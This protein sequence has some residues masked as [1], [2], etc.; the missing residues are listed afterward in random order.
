MLVLYNENKLYMAGAKKNGVMSYMNSNSTTKIKKTFWQRMSDSNDRKRILKLI[1]RW[2]KILGFLFIIISMIWGCVQ[3][4]QDPYLIQE[5]TDMTGRRVYMAGVS[6]EIITSSLGEKPSQN[7]AVIVSGLNGQ[8]YAYNVISSWGEAFSKTGSPFYGFFV[9]PTAL[10]LNALIKG[11][12]GTLNPELGDNSYG[13]AVI[14]AIL[15]TVI[16]IKSISLAFTWK[17]Q[18]NQHKQQAFQLKQADIQAK[19][20]GDKSPQAR[21]KM[22][23]EM[24]ALQKREGF[25]PFSS[26]AGAFASMPFLFAIYAIVRSTKSL[27][28]ANVGLIALIEKPWSQL[29]N[30]DVIYLTLLAVYLPLQIVSMLLPLV[31]QSIKQKSITLTEAQR[32]SRK[33]QY[34]M[35]GVFAFVFI[36]VVASVASGVAIYWIFSSTYQII[37]TLAFFF[38]N[39][40]KANRSVQE[41]KRRKRQEEKRLAK[42]NK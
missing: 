38:W 34:I 20:K 8:Q 15:F 32:S 1:W 7:W 14:F 10:L 24:S 22:S 37:Q 6:F 42:L 40:H 41:V 16:I 33:K 27:K 18:V 5:V 2:I 21:Q 28:I 13:I 12:S 35:Q 17:S 4:Y 11:M 23:A 39:Q 36:F 31:L 26:M 25:S 3:M 29:L 19:Y 9:Y 30:G